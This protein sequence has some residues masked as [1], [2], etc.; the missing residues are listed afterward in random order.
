MRDRIR[1]YIGLNSQD[2]IGMSMGRNYSRQKVGFLVFEAKIKWWLRELY[3]DIRNTDAV[4]RNG[5]EFLVLQPCGNSR[6]S[7]GIRE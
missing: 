7:F 3:Q 4:F 6:D 5:E 2:A 1:R